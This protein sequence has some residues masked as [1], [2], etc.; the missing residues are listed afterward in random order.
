M[1]RGTRALISRAALQ[2]NLQ[3]ARQCAPGARIWAVIKANGYGHDAVQVARALSTADGYAV[4][5]LDE[6]LQLRRAGINK[7]LLLLEGVTEAAHWHCVQQHQLTAVIHCFE[8]LEQLTQAELT[9]PLAVWLKIDTGMHRLGLRPDQ[10]AAALKRVQAQGHLQLQGVMTHLAC[11]DARSEAPTDQQLERFLALPLAKHSTSIAN[12]AAILKGLQWQG[13]WVRPGIMLYGASPFS[14]ASARS[15]QLRPVMRFEAPVIALRTVAK[16]EGIGYGHCWQ[17]Q[18]ESCIA[19]LAAGYGDG[20]PRHAPNGTPVWLRQQVV[21]LAGR[22][23]M[24]MLMVD[25]TDVPVVKLGDRA[26]LWGEQVAVDEIARRAGTIG[27]E[28]LTRVSS[29]VPKIAID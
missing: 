20:Y 19:T 15:L 5:T 23:S 18:R 1:S 11:A 9:E 7:P 8:Q 12:S 27:Y 6:A 2:Q 22:V 24:D 10:F 26:E 13:D 28:L 14:D 17:A 29:R 21:P 3:R 4:A 16:G 25:V